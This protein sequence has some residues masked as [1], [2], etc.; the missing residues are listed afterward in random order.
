MSTTYHSI[1]ALGLKYRLAD[2]EKV[3]RRQLFQAHPRCARRGEYSLH[4]EWFQSALAALTYDRC[5]ALR[6]NPQVFEFERQGR[7]CAVWL[8]DEPLALRQLFQVPRVAVLYH[9]REP[10]VIVTTRRRFLLTNV[11]SDPYEVYEVALPWS[12]VTPL[13]VNSITQL[14]DAL[15]QAGLPRVPVQIITLR[16][17]VN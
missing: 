4:G 16:H 7:K 13:A 12:R 9:L 3:A 14:G 17:L 6:S 2:F 15:A 5:P 8:R 10:L 1:T 11:E